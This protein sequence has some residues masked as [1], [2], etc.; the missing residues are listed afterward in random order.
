MTNSHFRRST[1]VLTLAVTALSGGALVAGASPAAAGG[2]GHHHHHHHAR[3][4]T[5]L[6]IH[7]RRH[8]IGNGDSDR[9]VGRLTSRHHGLA[10]RTVVLESKAPKTTTWTVD[11]RRV[12]HR[13][14]RAGFIV[15]PTATTRYRLV[16]FGGPALR[17]SRSGG[18]TVVVSDM[19]LTA[20][21]T[22]HSIDAGESATVSGVL[23]DIGAPVPGATVDLFAKRVGSHAGFTGA[24]S[25]MTGPDGSVAFPVTP[26]ASTRY[27]LV[28][29]ATTSSGAA[30]S[31]VVTVTVRSASTLSIVARQGRAGE[32]ISGA[33]RG[34]GHALRGRKVTLQ[35]RP[36]GDTTWTAAKTKRTHRHGTI[37][38]HVATPA[39]S[40]DYRLVFAG[41][42]QFDGTA[43][44]VVTLP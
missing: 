16:F 15:T 42:S 7:V 29:P 41:G 31:R 40:T 38:F 26:T 28:E 35:Q 21:A 23:T 39:A 18:R 25:A 37:R 19:R 12:T 9:I 44:G 27:R 24:G 17:P 5:A 43:S 6:G 11:G 36:S 4:A 10:R 30:A 13:H 8:V 2:P 22:P 32:V 33:L 14:G 3:S 1:T 34:G 20:T